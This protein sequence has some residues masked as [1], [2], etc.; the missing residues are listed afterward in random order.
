MMYVNYDTVP[1]AI[2]TRQR[3]PV[4]SFGVED[5]FSRR[6]GTPILFTLLP[7]HVKEEGEDICPKAPSFFLLSFLFFGFLLWGGDC[8]LFF[9]LLFSFFSKHCPPLLERGVK[10]EDEKK[11]QRLFLSLSIFHLER[12]IQGGDTIGQQTIGSVHS[13][14]YIS[15]FIVNGSPADRSVPFTL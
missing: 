1:T 8:F 13:T 2:S 11:N 7:V 10:E 5:C 12:V 4:L 15:C 9:S 14:L 3:F 6:G